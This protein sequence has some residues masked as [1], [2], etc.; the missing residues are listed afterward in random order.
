MRREIEILRGENLLLRCKLED[1]GGYK[2]KQIRRAKLALVERKL[3]QADEK[4][5]QHGWRQGDKVLELENR[6]LKLKL[7]RAEE[8]KEELNVKEEEE[9]NDADEGSE[10]ESY[11]ESIMKK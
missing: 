1:S 5:P 7:K 4:D 3:A 6:L 2:N 11:K 9:R 8:L 10:G